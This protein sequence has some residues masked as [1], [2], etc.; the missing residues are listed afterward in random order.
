VIAGFV[1]NVFICLPVAIILM[2]LVLVLLKFV[3]T[4]INPE[5]AQSTQQ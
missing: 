5:E 3:C 4:P 2:L 1:Q